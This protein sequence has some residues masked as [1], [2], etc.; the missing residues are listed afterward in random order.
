MR[1]GAGLLVALLL[2]ACGP[3]ADVRDVVADRTPSISGEGTDAFVR[4]CR[5][6]VYG[7]LARN[8]EKDAITVGR[9]SFAYLKVNGLRAAGWAEPRAGVQSLKVLVI[10]RSGPAQTVQILPESA[11]ALQY[12]PSSFDRSRSLSDGDPA[13]RFVPCGEGEGFRQAP[14]DETQFNGGFLAAEPV[15]ATLRAVEDGL[16]VDEVQV[17]L[18]GASCP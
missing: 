17:P 6:S 14:D 15:C 12:D 4:T 8:W 9:V 10:V 7:R 1:M 5:T 18:L 16:V 11:V 2:G 3:S 13:V